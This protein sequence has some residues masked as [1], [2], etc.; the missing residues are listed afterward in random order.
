VAA[1]VLPGRT[2]FTCDGPLPSDHDG[3]VIS[4]LALVVACAGLVVWPRRRWR[5]LRVVAGWRR[6]VGG[7]VRWL[8]PV[9]LVGLAV[10]GC[11]V[12]ARP[13]GALEVGHGARSAA[14]VE[15]R[16]GEEGAWRRCGYDAIVGEYR[17]GGLAVVNDALGNVLNDRPP[18]WPFITPVV[19]IGSDAEV[20]VEVRIVVSAAIHGRY[21]LGVGGGGEATVSVGEDPPVHVSAKRVMVIGDQGERRIEVVASVPVTGMEVALVREGGIEPGREFLVEPP[22]GA[23]VIGE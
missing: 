12:R 7:W 13:I 3:R 9:A 17:C 21:W 4:W 16:V 5:I 14:V 10:R 8:V 19:S 18:S 20:P 11:A 15:A 23:P 2:V 6:R 22:E 1:W